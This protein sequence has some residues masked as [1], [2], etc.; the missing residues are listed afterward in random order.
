MYFDPNSVQP[1]GSDAEKCLVTT[2]V[3]KAVFKTMYPNAES[4]QGF[5]SRGTGDTESEWVTKEDIRIAEY[6]YTERTKEMLLQLS[7][8]T[9]GFSDEIPS[10]E[11][12]EAAG[13]TLSLIHISEPT[14][15]Y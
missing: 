2:V 5:S 13:I 15:P 11:V 10:K 3:S 12:L 14:R 9:T 8:G 6:F 4:E 7:D 1:D